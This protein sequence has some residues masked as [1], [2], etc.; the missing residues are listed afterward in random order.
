[1]EDEQH[2]RDLAVDPGRAIRLAAHFQ[3]AMSRCYPHL[4]LN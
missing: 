1:M 4:A 3:A 2:Q